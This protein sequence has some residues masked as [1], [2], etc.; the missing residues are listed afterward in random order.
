MTDALP[1]IVS[2][3][4]LAGALSAPDLV[5]LD[6][7]AFL[8]GTPRD[9][10]AEYL[11]AHI[12]GA[13]FFPL[14]DIR[15]KNNPVP[16]M[17]PRAE[18][19]AAAVGARGVG[20]AH[21][22]V[23]YDADAYFSAP[24]VAFMFRVMGHDA[25]AVLDGGFAKWRAEGRPVEA[26]EV[27]RPPAVFKA[28]YR[29]EMVKSLEDMRANLSARGF[30]VADSRNPERF[31]GQEPEPRPGMR[32]GHIPG[33][34]NV[35]YRDLLRPDGTLRPPAE[36]QALF[37]KARLDLARPIVTSCGGG[38]TACALKLALEQAGARDVAVYDGSWA[39]WGARPD[40]PVETG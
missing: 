8:P 24:R 23:V 36:L 35:Y 28:R 29:P 30:Q 9:P 11:A 22:V 34:V 13:V 17:L 5:V 32:S 20:S 21:R 12:P 38:V 15:D 27:T 25:V 4:W 26:G 7:T 10:H 33:A 14:D 2:T 1:P 40:V 16:M 6:G 3:A 31:S 18:D 37:A 39:E 19:F